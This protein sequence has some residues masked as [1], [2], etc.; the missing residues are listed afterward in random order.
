MINSEYFN[1]VSVIIYWFKHYSEYHWKTVNISSRN[2]LT[3]KL[4]V[5]Q[6]YA[7]FE[8]VYYHY[9]ENI[10]IFCLSHSLKISDDF[11]DSLLESIY[12]IVYRT[13]YMILYFSSFVHFA[14]VCRDEIG[15]QNTRDSNPCIFLCLNR[16]TSLETRIDSDRFNWKLTEQ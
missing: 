11:T 9:K 6:W 7:L 15:P 1:V 13:I 8:S 2:C 16:S 14:L 4:T 3:V 5:F 12:L 10:E